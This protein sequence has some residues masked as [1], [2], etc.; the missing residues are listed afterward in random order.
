MTID[1]DTLLDQRA[2][3]EGRQGTQQ[4]QQ[5]QGTGAVAPEAVVPALCVLPLLRA[6][7]ELGRIHDALQQVDLTEDKDATVS[8]ALGGWWRICGGRMLW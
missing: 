6:M 5:G 3:Q 7:E 1:L 8:Q 4:G 2:Q